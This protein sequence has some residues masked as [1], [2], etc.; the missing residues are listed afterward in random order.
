[1]TYG[2]WLARNDARDGRK[3]APPHEIMEAI[4]SHMYEWRNSHIPK[5]RDVI[6]KQTQR[7]DVPSA[8][9]PEVAEVLA[10]RRAVQLAVE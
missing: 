7:W 3:I 8:T 10:C 5:V 6:P 2:L 1:M 9:D 4:V